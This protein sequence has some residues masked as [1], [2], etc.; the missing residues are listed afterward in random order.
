M[1]SKNVKIVDGSINAGT[2][3]EN[4]TGNWKTFK[5]E[6]DFNRCIHCMFCVNYCPDIC[7]PVKNEKRLETNLEMCKG[8]SIC[9]EICPVKCI[10]MVKDE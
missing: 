7:I 2:S 6:V 9:V 5:P 10:K 1:K 8:C 3:L 4:R